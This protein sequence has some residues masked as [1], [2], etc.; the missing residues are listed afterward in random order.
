MCLQQ[1]FRLGGAVSRHGF[2]RGQQTRV[3]VA[4]AQGRGIS[5]PGLLGAPHRHHLVAQDAPGAGEAGRARHGAPKGIGCGCILAGFDQDHSPFEPGHRRLRRC[6]H[7][8]RQ[9]RLCA[10]HLAQAAFCG[11]EQQIGFCVVWGCLQ[12]C[13]GLQPG[14]LRCRVHRLPCRDQSI[15]VRLT[16]GVRGHVLP[17]AEVCRAVWPGGPRLAKIDGGRG[18]RKGP[19]L[20]MRPFEGSPDQA[21]GAETR[22]FCLRRV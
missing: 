15:L 19:H 22:L 17:C 8:R 16:Q 20:A 12:E 14:L 13:L 9:P 3:G 1:S 4:G 5:L 7:E 10:H 2:K 6:R 11:R 18:E 21:G